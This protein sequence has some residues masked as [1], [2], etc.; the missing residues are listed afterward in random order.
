MEIR[1][2]Q[3]EETHS[4]EHTGLVDEAVS[5]TKSTIHRF[6]SSKSTLVHFAVP[7]PIIGSVFAH[8]RGRAS[9]E[10]S[11][12]SNGKVMWLNVCPRVPHTSRAKTVS[13]AR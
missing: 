12:A 6:R 13:K 3:K 9:L 10:M 1:G 4:L 11:S 7:M 5:R 8:V 2:A